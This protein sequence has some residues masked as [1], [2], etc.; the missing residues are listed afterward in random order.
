MADVP[1]S[2]GFMPWRLSAILLA[3]AIAAGVGFR[4]RSGADGQ[5]PKSQPPRPTPVTTALAVKSDF[6]VYL[7]GLGTVQAFNTVVIRTRVDGQIEK[8]AFAEGQTVREGDLLAQ[9]DARPFRAALDQAK[10]KK[11]QDEASLANAQI[12]LQRYT[13]LSRRN[14]VSA[15]QLAT[16]KSL[17]AQIT[18]Q[19]SGDQAAVD[20]A[21]T[22][23]GYTTIR[24]PINGIA[25]FRLVDQGNIA[26]ASAQT[27]IVN[28]TQ[29]EP[30]SV[31]F[32]APEDQVERIN[33]ALAAGPLAVTA[34]T[35][36]GKRV[37]SQGVLSVV[38]NQVDPAT[39]T[40]SLKATFPNKD[41]ALW[42]GLSVSTKLLVDTLHGVTVVPEDAV[43]RGPNGLY[44][45]LVTPAGTAE[46]RDI[47]VSHTGGGLSVIERGV[48]PGDR[49]VTAGQYRLAPDAPVK[50]EQ[51]KE[52]RQ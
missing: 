18:A 23:L 19:I 11:T 35:P 45:Y 44:V 46:L 34:L 13:E 33:K 8:I 41:H 12:D 27:G 14:A 28:I 16:Q 49:V 51:Q 32:T 47:M 22:Q 48:S 9:I 39:G 30:I 25:G 29:I 24:S 40:I 26:N 10:A 42:P 15:Q 7:F 43:K 3:A 6:P 52:A 17:V 36:D 50:F 4:L 38:N 31:V 37:L 2:P 1:P 20:N 21:Q 5:P